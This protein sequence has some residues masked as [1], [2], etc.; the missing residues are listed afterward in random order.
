[1]IRGE[2][3]IYTFPDAKAV[4]DTTSEYDL[5]IRNAKVALVIDFGGSFCRIGWAGE[6][7]PRLIFRNAF[8][9]CRKDSELQIGNAISNIEA[10]R[11]TT[12]TPFDRNVVT[13]LE[14]VETMLDYGLS[15]LSIDSPESLNHPVC[16]TEC[17]GCPNYARQMMN[18]VLFE[19]YNVPSVSYGIDSLFSLHYNKNMPADALVVSLGHQT[20]HL[21]PVLDGAAQLNTS[22]RINLGG[23]HLHSYMQKILQLRHP[24]NSAALTLS[25]IE[26]MFSLTK[27]SSDF[28]GELQQWKDPDYYEKHEVKVQLPFVQ[29]EKPPPANPQVVKAR[30]QELGRRLMEINARKREAKLA[31]NKII[32]G[33]LEQIQALHDQGSEA[34]FSKAVAK[35]NLTGFSDLMTLIGKTQAAIQKAEEARIREAQR[36][37]TIGEPDTKRRREDMCETERAEFDAWLQDVRTKLQEIREKKAARAQRR[38][39]LAKRRTAASQER[40]RIISQLARNNKEEDNFGVNDSDWDVYKQISRDAED[41]DSEEENLKAQEYET[42]LKEHSTEEEFNKNCADWHQ[43]HLSTELSVVPEILFQPSIIGLDQSGLAETIQFIFSKYS[44]ADVARLGNN[45]FL[46][47]GLAAIPGLKERLELEL[48]QILPFQSTF[49]VECCEDP[50]LDGWRGASAWASDPNNL[51]SGFLSKSEYESQGEGYLKEHACSNK[52]TATPV[53]PV[54]AEKPPDITSLFA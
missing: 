36:E 23:L 53:P 21:I 1:M 30:R 27:V 5:H 8:A 22:R 33:Q 49:K 28:F 3:S 50:V 47:G 42:V 43:V 40:M 4:V 45:V 18:Q 25:R 44:D 54:V 34:R 35:L 26:D 9:K 11:Q 51:K 38:Q 15:R 17:P 14:A 7:Q 37:E 48:R 39:Q 32:L 13:H 16:I 20:L 19:L 2:N 10:V 31:E 6:N 46:T 41:S 29:V 24:N 12:K 52:Y